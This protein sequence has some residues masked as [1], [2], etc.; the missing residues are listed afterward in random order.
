MSRN[1]A[2]RRDGLSSVSSQVFARGNETSVLYAGLATSGLWGALG[3]GRAGEAG[4]DDLTGAS[5]G[6]IIAWAGG[7]MKCAQQAKGAGRKAEFRG[8]DTRPRLRSALPPLGGYG[9]E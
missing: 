2:Q 1:T 6:L 8:R 7:G 4:G 5:A 9:G 3:G